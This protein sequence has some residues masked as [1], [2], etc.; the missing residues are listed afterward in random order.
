METRFGRERRVHRRT[1]EADQ[2]DIRAV[3]CRGKRVV[4]HARAAAQV[5]DHN[6]G[7]SHVVYWASRSGLT[8][9]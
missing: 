6:D 2:I 5:T 1:L 7:S 3:D 4:L 9:E 8:P